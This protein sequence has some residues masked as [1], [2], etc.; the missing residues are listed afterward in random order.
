MSSNN[1]YE[2]YSNVLNFQI[3][4]N[5]N[6]KIYK[7]MAIFEETLSM[8]PRYV[9]RLFLWNSFADHEF[10]MNAALTIIQVVYYIP[11]PDFALNHRHTTL[12]NFKLC[13]HQRRREVV[14]VVVG[15]EVGRKAAGRVKFHRNDIVSVSIILQSNTTHRSPKVPK[16]QNDFKHFNSI[17]Y[18]N[19]KINLLFN[20]YYK[21]KQ[22]CDV[23]T[24]KSLTT[25]S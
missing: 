12:L 17:Y 15:E 1:N 11:G 16:H 3:S 6:Y 14:L 23:D 22:A 10:K 2:N 25:D 4:V 21:L 5:F 9:N 8:H 24:V 18:S 7:P 13:H 20:Y 19:F